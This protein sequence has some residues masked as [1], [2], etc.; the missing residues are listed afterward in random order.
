M[1]DKELVF[2]TL[3]DLEECTVK[4]RGAERNGPRKKNGGFAMGLQLELI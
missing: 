1:N 2:A 4:A 3:G